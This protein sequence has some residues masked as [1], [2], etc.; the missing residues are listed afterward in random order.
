MRLFNFLIF[1]QSTKMTI[2]K[3]L[4][5]IAALHLII[6][7][8]QINMVV[9]QPDWDYEITSVNHTLL[10]PASAQI[11]ID[12]VPISNGDYIGVFYDSLGTLVCAGYKQ[13]QGVSMTI[14]AWGSSSGSLNGFASGEIFK[15]KIWQ[16]STG[17]EFEAEAVF[18]TIAFPNHMY[19]TNNGMSGLMSLAGVSSTGA[20]EISILSS[21]YFCE[22][23]DT[24][25]NISVL[26]NNNL[27]DDIHKVQLVAGISAIAYADTFIFY[28]TISAGNSQMYTISLAA[29]FAF[30]SAEELLLDAELLLSN[31]TIS[32]SINDT[33]YNNAK[34][35]LTFLYLDT[36]FCQDAIGYT[37]LMAEPSGG[38]FSGAN[39]LDDRFFLFD[40]GLFSISYHYTDLSTGCSNSADQHIRVF[41]TPI[42]NLPIEVTACEGDTVCL[43]VQEG[44]ESYT[45]SDGLNGINENCVLNSATYLVWVTSQQGCV[46]SDTS[47]VEFLPAP[48]PVVIGDSVACFGETIEL[49]VLGD[50]D[51]YQWT[52][53]VQT[54]GSAIVIGESGTYVATVWEKGCP[55]SDTLDV[56]IYPETP[57]AISGPDTACLGDEVYIHANGNVQY[58]TWGG[59]PFNFTDSL[60]VSTSG[61]YTAIGF[62]FNN[63]HSSADYTITFKLRPE[64]SLAPVYNLCVGD[65][66]IL[67]PG[68]ADTY[69]W[70]NDSSG[71]T[72]TVL[73]TGLYKV[74][75]SN[76]ACA[77]TADVFIQ[78]YN[79]PGVDFDYEVV[80]NEVQFFNY[81]SQVAHYNWNFGTDSSAFYEPFYTYDAIGNYEVCLT[82]TNSCGAS[83]LTKTIEIKDVFDDIHLHALDV[84]PN[85]GNGLFTVS[86]VVTVELVLDFVIHNSLGFEL[87]QS[88]PLFLIPGENHFSY[89]YSFL[90]P[91][92][93][94]L[95]WSNG[96]TILER[97]LVIAD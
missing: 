83:E 95:V 92:V 68:K 35:A 30:I 22:D 25:H 31:Q 97:T 90:P 82:A 74:T 14:A 78:F 59:N 66:V 73:E 12:T 49:S 17:L 96:Q 27:T 75:C 1:V 8:T 15:W 91:G 79:K 57:I 93:Y 72:L 7:A 42:V 58:F 9:A 61:T 20:T 11:T 23:A 85:P 69:V 76:G 26:V 43:E 18:N 87:V 37:L 36:V 81:S 53:Q 19:Y 56:L 54:T 70:N 3:Y 2:A 5:A 65:R 45:W 71:S 34:P 80:L 86:I 24:L 29:N 21:L 40:T 63:C 88:E 41:E 38:Y 4:I 55:G 33:I 44:Y 94:H 62:D 6:F 47:E 28:D 67:E 64:I 46:A 77:S 89:D 50:F 32:R 84:Y 16:S 52:G 51:F 39:V 10:V 13:W 60:L 48:N